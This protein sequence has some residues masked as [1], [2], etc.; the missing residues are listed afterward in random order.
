MVIV[1]RMGHRAL[2][3]GLGQRGRRADAEGFRVLPCASACCSAAGPWLES[4]RVQ[5]STRLV[6]P[7]VAN[8]VDKSRTF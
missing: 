7:V 2:D 6:C 3:R 8:P 4:L 5:W 1:F